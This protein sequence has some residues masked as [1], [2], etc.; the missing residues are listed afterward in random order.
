MT[1]QFQVHEA[2]LYGI[3]AAIILSNIRFW[4]EK[5]KANNKHFKMGKYWTYNSYPAFLSLFPY[6]SEGIIKRS[7]LKLETAGVLISAVLNGNGYDR[8]K[9]YSIVENASG[10]NDTNHR[11]NLDGQSAN[12]SQPIPDINTNNKPDDVSTPPTTTQIP[13]TYDDYLNDN[14]KKGLKECAYD[15]FYTPR[16][17]QAVELLCMNLRVTEIGLKHL[18]LEFNNHRALSGKVEQNVSEWGKHFGNWAKHPKRIA[19]AQNKQGNGLTAA[20]NKE[21]FGT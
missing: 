19:A 2:E 7:I 11:P 13:Y 12:N 8:T 4:I 3:E 1:H 10:Q 16:W 20:E 14:K 5:N 21:I 17:R 6:M 9:W 15:Y 18:A